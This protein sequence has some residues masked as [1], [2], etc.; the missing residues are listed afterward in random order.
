MAKTLAKVM[1]ERGLT[2]A[3]VSGW[4]APFSIH[5]C[6]VLQGLA[7]MYRFGN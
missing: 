1:E 5:P 7:S 2:Q 4:R 6:A 3:E